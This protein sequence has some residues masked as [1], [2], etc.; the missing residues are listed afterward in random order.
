MPYCFYG[1]LPASVG[2]DFNQSKQGVLSLWRMENWDFAT[3]FELKA[4][5]ANGFCGDE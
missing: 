5:G 2:G 1:D 4:V 3:G